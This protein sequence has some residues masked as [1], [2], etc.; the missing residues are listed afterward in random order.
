MNTDC[1]LVCLDGETKE[2][3]PVKIPFM[4]RYPNKGYRMSWENMHVLSERQMMR[5]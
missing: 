1:G 5:Q 4:V 2:A 3:N